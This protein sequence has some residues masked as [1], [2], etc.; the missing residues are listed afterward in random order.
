M[1]VNHPIAAFWC[2]IPSSPNFGDALTPW[3]IRRITGQYPAF[4]RPEDE[5]EKYFVTGSIMEY[6]RAACTVWG[7]GIISRHDRI[8]PEATLL[9]VRGPLTRAR[10]LA[11]GASCPEIY[12]D[13]ALLLPRLYQ[14]TAVERRG[15]GLVAHFSDK[16][17]LGAALRSIPGLKLIDIQAPVES[18][19]NQIAS[20][21]FV[22]SS[23]LHGL[24]TSHAYGVPAVWVRF[25][26]LPAGDGSKFEDY[27]LSI[28]QDLPPPVT[29]AYDH[30]DVI[31][32]A[33]QVVLPSV[34]LDLKA[35]YN[36][37]PFT[38]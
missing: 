4:L 20:C 7:S 10:A 37:C 16:P 32:L 3:L 25:R 2:R 17:H 21:E 24:I 27:F 18:V 30:I 11:C 14:P 15:A 26:P 19:I 38:R 31:A 33:N 5:G 6:T 13:P 22:A 35:L 1:R 34:R 36:A 8:S 23:S 29:V 9:A 28:G 12:G